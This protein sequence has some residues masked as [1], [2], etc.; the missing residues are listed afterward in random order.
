VYD[1]KEIGMNRLRTW[2]RKIF[3]IVSEGDI[4]ILDEQGN[5]TG[6]TAHIYE[7]HEKGYWHATANVYVVNSKNEVLLQKRSAGM[8]VFPNMWTLSAGGHVRAKQNPRGAAIEEVYGEL[9]IQVTDSELIPLRQTR[10]NE[11]LLEGKNFDKEFHYNFLVK[12]DFEI[13]EVRT[14][15]M[16]LSDV[17]W[18][19][20][21][22]YRAIVERKDP[23]H[24]MHASIPAF[25][26]YVDTVM[27]PRS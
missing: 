23:N 5:P 8:R 24:V 12:K 19:P 18:M 17:Q 6:E 2:L 26:E 3:E 15:A 27:A 4:D 20:I 14:G 13:S 21:E 1:C 22:E 11:V 25:F 16:E 9:G 7:I 10:K